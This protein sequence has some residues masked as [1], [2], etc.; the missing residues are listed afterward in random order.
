MATC[1]SCNAKLNPDKLR[2]LN[3]GVMNTSE[4]FDVRDDASIALADVVSADEDRLETGPWD[5]C[6]GQSTKTGQA[7]IVKTSV[8]LIGGSPGAGKSTITLQICD[9]VGAQ[10]LECIYIATEEALP[11]IKMRADRLG[12]KH[13]EFIRMV[14]GLSGVNLVQ[15]VNSRPTQPSLVIIDSLNNM[16]GEDHEL[17]L[18]VCKRAKEFAVKLACPFFLVTHVTKD[19]VIAG[20]NSIQHAVDTTMTFFPDED[21]IRILNVLKN[22]FGRAFVETEFEMTENGLEY[23]EPEDSEE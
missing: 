5:I 20:R 1:S 22:R 23:L 10:K 21:G 12:L 8:T 3:C 17:Q 7:G 2:C 4:M 18:E 9:A 11:E 19:E 15:V 6:F 14:S 13:Q 16:V